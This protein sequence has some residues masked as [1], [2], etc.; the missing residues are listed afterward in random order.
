MLIVGNKYN[1]NAIEI[2][3]L[4]K[5]FHTVVNIKCSENNIDRIISQIKAILK[6]DKHN[7]IVL[8]ITNNNNVLLAQKFTTKLPNLQLIAMEVFLEKYLYKC[9]VP[10]NKNDFNLLNEITGYSKLQFIQKRVIDY[11]GLF[12]LFIFSYLIMRK[13]RIKINKESKGD[14]YFRQLRIGIN[15]KEFQCIKFRSMHENTDF[16]HH[17]T[18][19]DDPRIFPW[20]AVMRKRRYDELPQ[21]LNILQGDMHLIGPRAEWSK[22]AANYQQKIFFYHKRHIITPGI[23][24]WAQVMYSY[25]ENIEDAKQKLMYDLYYIKYWSILLELKIVFK[26]ALVVLHKK[27]I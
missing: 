13:C 6:T 5:K 3:V 17:Y 25:G 22:L 11:F 8:N 19:R 16:F 24:G 12:F 23:T 9:Y 2:I 14:I 7:N 10:I 18:Q 21:M 20:G 1:F 15:S 4:K 26:T 27:G